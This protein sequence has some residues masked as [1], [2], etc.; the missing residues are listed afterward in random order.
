MPVWNSGPDAARIVGHFRQPADAGLIGMVFAT[1]QP[2]LENDVQANNRQSKLL[3][4]ALGV[5]TNALIAVPL[6]C[7]EACRG[8]VSCVQLTRDGG[9]AHKTPAGFNPASLA[10][11]Q[12]AANLFSRLIEQRLMADIIG[13]TPG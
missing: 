8:I 11:V 4:L 3:D 6:H 10:Q 9:V 2:F 5:R 13:L 12:R 7:V 1:E